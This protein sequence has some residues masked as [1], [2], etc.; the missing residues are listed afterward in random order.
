M[1][2]ISRTVYSNVYVWNNEKV[3]KRVN[4]RNGVEARNE[5]RLLR[6]LRHSPYVVDLDFTYENE[7]NVYMV[8]EHC[9]YGC[10][11]DN[12]TILKENRL[13]QATTAML[14]CIME[15]HKNNIIH[16]DIKLTNF[17]VDSKQNTK[18]IDFGCSV[19]VR[20]IAE[21][22]ECKQATWYYAAPEN[23]R[24]K[25]YIQSDMWSL[26]V[27]VYVMATGKHPYEYENK[28]NV[29]MDTEN[30]YWKQLSA[31]CQDFIK[32]LLEFEYTSRMNCVDAFYH[33]FIT[34]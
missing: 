2:L 21:E 3:I 30:R 33:P 10:M 11:Y 16:G 12:Y 28:W 29:K 7:H 27:C 15:C 19:M 8:L 6:V 4:K 18:L 25:R 23:M 34:S 20:S 13:K 26:G 17:V 22:A 24:S 5:I 14:L 32:R 1:D 31:D 9:K